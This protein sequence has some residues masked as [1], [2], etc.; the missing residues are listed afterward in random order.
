MHSVCKQLYVHNTPVNVFMNQVDPD[1][2]LSLCNSALPPSDLLLFNPEEES[3]QFLRGWLAYRGVLAS[4][5]EKNLAQQ[6]TAD[7]H[8]RRNSPSITGFV[9]FD[10]REASD[11]FL[12][13]W[14]SWFGLGSKQKRSRRWWEKHVLQTQ[15]LRK[16]LKGDSKLQWSA[17]VELQRKIDQMVNFVVCSGAVLAQEGWAEEVGGK[18]E[19]M[20][21]IKQDSEEDAVFAKYADEPVQKLKKRNKK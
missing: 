21:E 6:A 13:V 18:E 7:M 14:M 11:D 9:D 4:D 1:L 10:V 19:E 16:S 12:R 15:K 17:L 20:D 5:D 8:K 2:V 3:A